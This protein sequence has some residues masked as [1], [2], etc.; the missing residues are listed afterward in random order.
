MV[1]SDPPIGIEYI[2][3]EGGASPLG[4]HITEPVVILIPLPRKKP[5]APHRKKAKKGM[6]ML[7]G[8]KGGKREIFYE[9]LVSIHSHERSKCPRV[10]YPCL[11]SPTT[12]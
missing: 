5:Q 9:P 2:M 3:V 8:Q 6:G 11:T 7:Y 4:A 10:L 12:S 1:V